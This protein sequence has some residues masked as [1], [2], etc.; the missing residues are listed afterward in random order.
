[1]PRATARTPRADGDR[2]RRLGVPR[3]LQLHGHEITVRI[4]PLSKWPHTKSAVGMYDPTL[5]RIDIRGDQPDT[6]VQQTFCH[7]L[8]HALLDEMN[9]KLSHDEVFVDTLGSL[10][11]QA[12]ASFSNRRPSAR[13]KSHR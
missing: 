6:A 1:M 4:L 5:H 3:R 8:V 10:L 12:L 11:Q 7:E 9:H 2:H 13:A